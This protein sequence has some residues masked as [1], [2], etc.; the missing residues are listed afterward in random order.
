MGHNNTGLYPLFSP[1]SGT[2]I[3]TE[4]SSI[5]SEGQ[6]SGTE[7]PRAQDNFRVKCNF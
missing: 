3:Q 2:A 7:I 1:V 5:V 4:L 6:V